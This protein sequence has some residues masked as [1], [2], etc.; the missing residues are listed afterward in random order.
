MARPVSAETVAI[1][2]ALVDGPGTSAELAARC[3]MERGAA[4]VTLDNL[5]RRCE[6]DKLEPIRVQGVK[7]PVPVYA[8]AEPEDIEECGEAGQST[9]GVHDLIAVW[10][11]LAPAVDQP[12]RTMA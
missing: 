11:G 2:A 7:R 5:V 8:R 1:L 12:R 9:G 10:A 6:V 4:M 3:G